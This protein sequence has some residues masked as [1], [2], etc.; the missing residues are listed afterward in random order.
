[1]SN[2]LR[3]RL[4]ELDHKGKPAFTYRRAAE[5]NLA[6]TFARI[7][8]EQKAAEAAKPAENVTAIKR[9]AK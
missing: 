2:P 7:K 4:L 3:K 6:A 5:T 1:M 8:R 9:R